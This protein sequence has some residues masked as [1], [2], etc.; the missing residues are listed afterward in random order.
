MTEYPLVKRGD[1]N[2]L[3]RRVNSLPSLAFL[4]KAISLAPPTSPKDPNYLKVT[5]KVEALLVG[6]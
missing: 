5:V 6:Q 3:K 2:G 1:F 4:L